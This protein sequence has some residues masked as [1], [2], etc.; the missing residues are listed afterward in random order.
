ML[1]PTESRILWLQQFGRG[2][3]KTKDDKKLT[4]IDYIGNHRTFLL[5]PQT[6]FSLPAGGQEILNL[7]ERAR[8]GQALLRGVPRAPR[9]PPARRRGLPRG[10]QPAGGPSRPREMLV[11]LGMLN[12]DAFPGEIAIDALAEW[13]AALASRN[14]RLVTDLGPK[15]ATPEGLAELASAPTRG[16]TP[17]DRPGPCDPELPLDLPERDARPRRPRLPGPPD[18]FHEAG[19]RRDEIVLALF[20]GEQAQHRDRAATAREHDG[21]PPRLAGV[22]REGCR[23]LRQLH[24]GHDKSISTPP[25]STR[26]LTFTPMARIV[27]HGIGCSATS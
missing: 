4:V 5:K 22:G 16:S 15:G 2:L 9:R 12:E 1:R 8:E 23:R 17:G 10:L 3:R 18:Q 24:S 25:T 14:Q 20:L 7:L 11:L 6:L 21:A 13:V 19:I 26:S 27:T